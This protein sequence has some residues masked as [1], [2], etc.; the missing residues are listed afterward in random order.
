MESFRKYKGAFETRYFAKLLTEMKKKYYDPKEGNDK[1]KLVF[2]LD[3]LAAHKT[4]YIM[5]LM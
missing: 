4:T 5:R 3:N 2:I 1:P